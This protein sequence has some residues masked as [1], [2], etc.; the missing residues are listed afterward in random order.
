MSQL[1]PK[2][3]IL[4]GWQHHEDHVAAIYRQLGFD[5]SQNV[6]VDGQQVDL[7]CEKLVVGIGRTRLCIDCKHTRL[8]ENRSVTKDDVD[9]FIF[10]FRNRAD[11]NGWTAGIMVS[12]R[13]FSQYAK[14]AA[15]RHQNVHLKTIA[16]LHEE[17]LHIRSYLHDSVRRYE[18]TN[19]FL[20]F[21]TPYGT[22]SST[23][24]P[25]IGPVP[26]KGIIDRWLRD[27]KSPQLCL[28][29]DF[30]TGKTTFLEYL[31]YTLAKQY[32]ANSTVRI[33]LLIPLRGYYEA[34]DH[35]E[36]IKQFFSLECATNLQYPLFLEFL[37]RGRLLLLL[38]GFD[39]MGARSDALTRK[40]NYLKLSGFVEGASKVLVS[41]RPAYFL[42]REE[43]QSVF[44]FM[45]KQIGFAPPLTHDSVS[46]QLY[47]KVQESDLAPVFAKTRNILGATAYAHLSLFD[48]RQIQS[49]LRKHDKGIK[50][51]SASQLDAKGLF[52][53][54]REIYDLEDLAK[55]PLLL[56]LIVSTLPLFK[57]TESG[58]FRFELQGDT[59]EVAEVTPSVLYL[60]YTE[61]E[62]E[63]E[64]RKG[65]VRWLID[66]RDKSRLITAI[67]FEMLKNDTL[68]IDGR[69]LAQIVQKAFPED[70]VEQAYYL[71]DIRTCSFLSRDS[72]DSIR[73]THKSFME[74]YAAV[75]IRS[76]FSGSDSAQ[77]LLSARTLNDE[78]AFFVGD[79]I[80]A[81]PPPEARSKIDLLV[82]I[83]RRLCSVDSPSEACVQNILNVLNY[84]RT[85]ISPVRNL[86]VGTIVYRKLNLEN[87]VWEGMRIGLLRTVKV[88][89]AKLDFLKTET[90]RWDIEDSHIKT[91]TGNGLDVRG[92]RLWGSRID[93]LV[94][95]QS[96]LSM[97]TWRDSHLKEAELHDTVVNT[98]GDFGGDGWL[99]AKGLFRNC[100]LVGM[101]LTGANSSDERKYV[102]CT[103]LMCRADP[104]RTAEKS[105]E[106]CRGVLIDDGAARLGRWGHN[107]ASCSPS[108]A[109]EWRSASTTQKALTWEQM[110]IDLFDTDIRKLPKGA[111]EIRA[112]LR[113]IDV[114]L[115]LQK[116]RGKK[117]MV[118][119]ASSNDECEILKCNA[120]TVTM[121]N[122]RKN[123]EFTEQLRRASIEGGTQLR[124]TFT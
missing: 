18:E 114:A 49:Y 108:V 41:C 8:E 12:N 101:H 5:V 26:L 13:P 33:P 86:R 112:R 96:S 111:S 91:L 9:Q 34:A 6:N 21:I 55:R 90:K 73:F 95:S 48:V 24:T 77:N 113:Q 82:G 98:T 119:G 103:F 15:A 61:N 88:Q 54:I 116:Y 43:T 122:L 79:G 89:A 92:L 74:Y 59:R 123:L 27:E 81:S 115:E 106:G 31:H 44:S 93:R 22:Q 72:Q 35:K 60:V 118:A 107:L 1:N 39:E 99:P 78:I 16:E 19:H 80:A 104:K 28:F 47:S 84:A 109:K 75:S 87:Q 32:L 67:A 20:D 30:G 94:L 105:M 58:A 52:Q 36:I 63:R 64:Y 97:E 71:T 42:S 120:H 69:T 85:P 62:L 117:V 40:A 51:A 25:G 70:E 46:E 17:V 10:T 65:R 68:G 66:R 45:A 83:Y 50:E 102:D 37:T 100:V 38:D 110:V 29:G 57:K 7:V 11:S 23:A 56:K 121:L 3:E 76:E 124:V 14:G 2:P 4:P 53:R